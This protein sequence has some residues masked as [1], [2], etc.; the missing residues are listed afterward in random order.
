MVAN[1]QPGRNCDL[2][3]LERYLR[4]QVENSLVFGWLPRQIAIITNFA[5]RHEQVVAHQRSLNTTC[6]TGSKIFAIGDFLAELPNDEVVWCHDLDVWQNSPFDAPDFKEIGIC[7]YST[8]KYNGGSIFYRPGALDLVR[9]IRDEIL[10]RSSNKEEPVINDVLRH[11]SHSPRVT[12]LNPTFNVGCSGYRERYLR[13]DKPLRCVHFHPTN[14]IAWDT[15]ARNRNGIGPA[16]TISSALREL[17]FRHFGETI[18]TFQYED[19]L[20]PL[21]VRPIGVHREETFLHCT[22]IYDYFRANSERL[23]DEQFLAE[24]IANRFG[25]KLNRQK[26]ELPRMRMGGVKSKQY[27]TELAAFLCLLHQER[28]QLNSYLEIGV[29]NGGTFFIIDSYLRVVCPTY[30]ESL[31]IDLSDRIHVMG[32]SEYRQRFP[33]CVFQ[34]VNSHHF[35]VPKNFSC[36]LIDGDHSYDGVRA[37]YLKL[38]GHVSRLIAFHDIAYRVKGYGICKLWDELDGDKIEIID[39]TALIPLGIGVIRMPQQD[40]DGGT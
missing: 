37:D 23:T 15:H 1:F 13:S 2:A 39:R 30:E 10:R 40:S 6:L 11:P 31:G 5:F 24:S 38:R 26:L 20:G 19:E 28:K 33:T 32:L 14:R 4:A 36:C 17:L 9:T 29:E 34:Q 18:G 12:E 8:P 3:E 35:E 27:P 22:E 16:A 7:C 25:T 21:D